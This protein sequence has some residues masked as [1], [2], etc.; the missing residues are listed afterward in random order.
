MFD[1]DKYLSFKEIEDIQQRIVDLYQDEYLT[2]AEHSQLF[3]QMAD[4]YLHD[5]L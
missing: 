1:Y 4:M 2:P 5:E 3:A